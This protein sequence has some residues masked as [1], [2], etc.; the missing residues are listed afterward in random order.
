MSK[1]D[2]QKQMRKL[3]RTNNEMNISIWKALL[4]VMYILQSKITS[5]KVKIKKSKEQK[6]QFL[7]KAFA[8]VIFKPEESVGK[9]AI[10]NM[11]LKTLT[12]CYHGTE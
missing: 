4:H 3:E 2:L 10:L 9:G 6:L 11:S 7:Y 8:K 1:D 12:N 5:N